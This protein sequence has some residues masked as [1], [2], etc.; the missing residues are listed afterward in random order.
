MSGNP[1]SDAETSPRDR[2]LVGDCVE[3]M[4]ALP[5]ASVD[6]VFADPPYNLQL[7]GD[8]LRPN[9]TKVDGVDDEWDRFDSFGAYDGFTRNWLEAA[10]RVL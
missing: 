1:L 7:A 9:N 8:L 3:V 10:R 2:I 6:V 5:A 4:N